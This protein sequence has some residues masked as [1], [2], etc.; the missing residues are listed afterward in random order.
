PVPPGVPTKDIGSHPFP[1]TGPYM[2][3]AVTPDSV[4]LVRNNR[5]HVW[6]VAAEP[7]GYPDRILVRQWPSRADAVKAV[8]A[9]KADLVDVTPF[10][11]PDIDLPELRR[12][13]P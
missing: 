12:N 6:S 8:E 4:L 1:G 5:F 10:G 13:Y 11:H 7:P 3:S 2:F 9:G